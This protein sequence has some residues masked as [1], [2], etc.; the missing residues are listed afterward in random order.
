MSENR[1][2]G[3]RRTARIAGV[4]AAAS[5]AL[6]LMST[7]AANADTFVPL[8][9]G[10]K[11]AA[12]VS[13][14]RV[15]ERAIISPSLSANGAGRTAWLSGKVIANVDTPDGTVGPNNGPK[16]GPGSNN[17]STHGTSQVNTGYIIGCQVNISDS[18]VSA[19]VSG[20]VSLT[21]ANAGGSIGLNLG[22][23]QVTFVQVNSKDIPSS[24]TYSIDYKDV[25]VD[26]QGC[27]G[28]AQA[29]A[30]TVVE[31]IGDNYSKTTLYG[32]PFSLG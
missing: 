17:S 22:P 12:G 24:G 32:Q 6:G 30:Y 15:G 9:D 21:G 7:G 13:I 27:A 18:A 5:V 29:R 23:G 4:G 31:I 10:H 25:P 14:D 28:Y 11:V 8:P 1:T 3:L 19:G 16:N 20:G 2:A 26:V